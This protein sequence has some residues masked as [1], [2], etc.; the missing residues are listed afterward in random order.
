[1]TFINTHTLCR[2]HDGS[3]WEPRS[4]TEHDYGSETAGEESRKAKKNYKMTRAREMWRGM[5]GK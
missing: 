4:R 2:V 3:G 5:K 1:M